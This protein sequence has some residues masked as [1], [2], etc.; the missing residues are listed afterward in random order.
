MNAGGVTIHSFFQLPFG[1]YLPG[2]ERQ[3]KKFSRE[4][5]GIIRSLDLLVI[6]EISMV[7]ADVLDGIDDVLRRFKNRNQP[8]GGVQLLMIGDLQQLAPVAREE[9]WKLLRNY[10]STVFFFGSRA[11]QQTRYVPITLQHIYRQ[12]DDRFIQIL[13]GIREGNLKPELLQTLNQR[14]LP[15]LAAAPPEGYITLTTHNQQAQQINERAL[16]KISGK[17]HTFKA[18]VEG[19]FP[20]YLYPAEPELVLKKGAQVM[21]LKNDS[22]REKRYYNGKIGQVAHIYEDTIEV[23]CPNEVPIYL[24]IAEWPNYK[25]SLN[26]ETKEIEE[27]VAGTF[28]QYPLKLAWAITIHKSQGLTFDKAIIDA[29]A[30]FTH[31][32]VYVALSRCRSLEGLVLTEPLATRSIISDATVIGFN[33]QVAQ[34][35]P[36]QA[37]LLAARQAYQQS[38]LQELFSFS[39]LDRKL[40]YGQKLVQEHA[41]SLAGSLISDL[42][43]LALAYQNHVATVAP[44]FQQQLQKLGLYGQEPVEKNADLQARV[45]QAAV[46]F[47]EKLVEVLVKPLPKL[48]I[49]TDNQESRKE[50][51]TALEGLYQEA[52]VKHA[53]LQAATEGFTAAAYLQARA[54]AQLE[55]VKLK[56]L[57]EDET[58]TDWSEH[59]ELYEQLKQYRN[60]KA[61][62]LDLPH[63]MILPLKTLEALAAQ[64]PRTMAALKKVKG[65]GKKKI[66]QMG[67]ELLQIINS[68]ATEAPPPE[69]P[70]SFEDDQQTSPKSSSQEQSYTL[71]EEGHSVAQI[72]KMRGLTPGTIENHLLPYLERGEIPIDKLVSP[73]KREVIAAYFT[74]HGFTPLKEARE[75]LG[76]GI[77]YFELRLVRMTMQD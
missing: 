66:E 59:P 71:F 36:D 27:T 18:S 57:T 63:Y 62:E 41:A 24:D 70:D 44:K 43:T 53:C 76:E 52:Y 19:D 51:K 5:I 37:Q 34:N 30:A 60:Q 15:Q 69:E 8:F 73:E 58:T 25:Y 64:Q 46:Y 38:L 35:Q 2:N 77:S 21:F 22:G 23:Q 42:E 31:G 10:Y 33:G 48:R 1:P 50:L 4:K 49:E 17:Q 68:L 26:Q 72:A 32:Q 29:N 39:A 9:E 28:R 56:R 65:L 13:N 55:G 16:Q 54:K 75:I 47:A 40:N 6:D 61:T 11:L 67:S 45:V 3:I 12:R 20:E 14:C 74:Q 7:R